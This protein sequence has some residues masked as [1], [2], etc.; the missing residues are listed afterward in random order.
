MGLSFLDI[1]LF[2]ILE[3]PL[4]AGQRHNQPRFVS[5]NS[6]WHRVFH[7]TLV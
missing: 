1:F 3:P 4:T 7:I 5:K 6:L 2:L